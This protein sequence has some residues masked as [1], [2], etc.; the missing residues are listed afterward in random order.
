MSVGVTITNA[1]CI[2]LSMTL[3]LS[4]RGRIRTLSVIPR[5][6]RLLGRNGDP[7]MSGRVATFLGTGGSNRH[8][9]GFQT[10][11]SPRRTCAKTSCTVITAPAGC[12]TRG[13]CFSASDIRT[14]VTTVHGCSGTT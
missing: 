8:P 9:L 5:G 2:N 12:S 7:V 13:G 4:R 10:A 14:T 3:L 11:L 6:I 1:K